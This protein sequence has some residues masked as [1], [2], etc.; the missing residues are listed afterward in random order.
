V[1]GA[2]LAKVLGGEEQPLDRYRDQSLGV[3][4]LS[5]RNEMIGRVFL[6]VAQTFFLLAPAV[7]YL[8]AGLLMANGSLTLTAGT[9]VAFTALQ[10]RLFT[11]VRDLLQTGIQ[12][13]S[14]AP[15]FERVFQYLDLDHEIVEAPDARA[16]DPR[17]VRGEI[18]F[19][20]VSFRY[21]G[22]T[23]ARPGAR[24]WTIDSVSLEIRPGQLAALVGPS[25]AG[26]TTLTYLLARLYDVQRGSITIDGVDLRRLKLSSLSDLLGVVT[27]ETYLLHASVR[28]NLLYARPEASPEELEHAARLALIHE[29]IAELPDGYETIVGERGYR[30]SGGEKQRPAIARVTLKAPSILILDE[31]TSSLDTTSERLVQA[32]L[33]PLMQGRTTLAI[34]HRL[35]TILKADVIFVLDRGRVVEQGTHDELLERGGLY[36]QLYE[37]Q[38]RGGLVQAEC[39]DGVVLATGEVVRSGS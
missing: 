3:A 35:S 16:L 20:D 33:E 2:L 39:E 14:S 29:R 28:D 38:F 7:V 6:G 21:G 34:A 31:A 23:A 36:A 27:Q 15:L 12:V 37:Q 18:A 32:A 8:G 1:S 26:K 19:D 22:E 24:T 5:V 9:L 11:P 30:L 13:Q 17:S 10:I 25:G 4:E